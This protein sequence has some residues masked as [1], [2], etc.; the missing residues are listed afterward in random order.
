MAIQI[1]IWIQGLFSGFVSI[2]VVNGRSF[3]LI[4]QMAALVRQALAEVC[5]VPVLVVIAKTGFISSLLFPPPS[6]LFPPTPV[7]S[8]RGLGSCMPPPAGL[9]RARPKT[10]FSAF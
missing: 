7:N 1:T 4:R 9:G 5:T 3:I 10:H 8:V 6:H 2:E